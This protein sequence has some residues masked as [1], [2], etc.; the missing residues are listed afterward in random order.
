MQFMTLNNQ[1]TID[2]DQ[3]AFNMIEYHR[4]DAKMENDQQI[5][6]AKLKRLENNA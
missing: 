6:M 1:V 3:S 2:H 5:I 4:K